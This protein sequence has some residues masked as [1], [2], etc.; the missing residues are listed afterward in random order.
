LLIEKF[1]G[2]KVKPPDYWWRYVL[3]FSLKLWAENIG[4][5]LVELDK[6][7]LAKELIQKSKSKKVLKL[8]LPID[9]VAGDKFDAQANTQICKITTPFPMAGWVLGYRTRRLHRFFSKSN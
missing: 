8:H 6:L 7:D 4:N 3:Y 5:S 2:T 1:A 9:S